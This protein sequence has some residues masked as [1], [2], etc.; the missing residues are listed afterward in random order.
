M[1]SAPGSQ[2]SFE[3]RPGPSGRDEAKQRVGRRSARRAVVAEWLG[4]RRLDRGGDGGQ[5]VARTRRV[6]SRASG[7][8]EDVGFRR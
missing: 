6:V 8:D 5:Q 7:S 3:Q 4:G 1:R 2:E